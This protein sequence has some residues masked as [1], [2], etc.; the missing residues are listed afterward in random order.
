MVFLT[1]KSAPMIKA[2]G[3][4]WNQGAQAAESLLGVNA[5]VACCMASVKRF[6]FKLLSLC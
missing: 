5:L 3:Y 4:K 6:D 1:E 2:K